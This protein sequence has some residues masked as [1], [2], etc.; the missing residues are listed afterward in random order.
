MKEQIQVT[1]EKKNLSTEEIEAELS[2]DS[3]VEENPEENPEVVANNAVVPKYFCGKLYDYQQ[4]GLEWLKLL[5]ENGLGGILAD[6]MGLGKTIQVIALICH[7]VE[8]KQPGPYLI[9][10]PLSTV[11]NWLTEFE[12]FA[13]KIPVVLFYGNQDER[14]AQR[15]K[16]KKKYSVDDYKT[17]P[18]VITSQETPL[19]ESRFLQSQNW[20]YLVVD[21]GQRIKNYNCKLVG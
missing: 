5:Y 14:L 2:I 8:T 9:V 13:P 11:P 16:I 21:E 19:H 12:R 6:E 4:T 7:F 18:V 17:Q 15:V 1:K 3:D 10:V 20:R